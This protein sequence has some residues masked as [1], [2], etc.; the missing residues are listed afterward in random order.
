MSINDRLNYV[1]MKVRHQ[2]KLLPWYKKWWGVLLIIILSLV[3]VLVVFSAIFLFIRI[4]EIR[5]EMAE[6]N[7]RISIENYLKRIEGN[8]DN[9]YLGANKN[10]DDQVLEV[11]VFGNF[12]CYYSALSS[13][14]IKDL[15][16]TYS[17]NVRFIYRDYPD[18]DSIILA[19]GAR[20]AGD[21]GKFWEMHDFIFEL[22]DE[23]STIFDEEEKRYALLQMAE[24]FELNV[25]SFTKCLD[26]K[27]HLSKVRRDYE[28]GEAL[29]I[30]G[31]PTWFI[32]AIEITGGLNKEKF[33]ELL[34]ALNYIN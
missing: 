5:T 18:P 29:G 10:E 15:A 20:C 27:I 23:L 21:Q 28:D 6:E 30:K 12:S 24:I 7:L 26:D 14:T 9:Y 19:L 11:T 3:F 1:K 31:T 22:Q 4:K 13:L 16:N 33:E 2:N 25:Q 32:N 8:G 17:N 34:S